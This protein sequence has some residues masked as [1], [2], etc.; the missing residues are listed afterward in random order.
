[1]NSYEFEKDQRLEKCLIQTGG[2]IF[3]KLTPNLRRNALEKL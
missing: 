2:T 1:M 3:L